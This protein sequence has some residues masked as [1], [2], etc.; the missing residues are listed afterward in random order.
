MTR[1]LVWAGVGALGGV[2]AILRVVLDAA[3]S[4]RAGRSF[5]FG[6]LAVDIVVDVA[7]ARNPLADQWWVCIIGRLR[8]GSAEFLI[9]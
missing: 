8:L 9:P 3:V 4:E 6:P 7:H 5:P 2:G 1:V